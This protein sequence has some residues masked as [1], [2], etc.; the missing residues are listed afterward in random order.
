[1][2]PSP[3]GP[4]SGSLPPDYSILAV[5]G[6][7]ERRVTGLGGVFFRSKNPKRLANWYRQHLGLDVT[8]EGGQTFWPFQWKQRRGAKR[9]GVTIWAPFPARSRYFGS[10]RQPIMMNYI[11]EDLDRVLRALRSERVEIIGGVEKSEY[12]RF[13]WI[14]D[15]EGHRVELWEPSQSK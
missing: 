4:G 9:N 15:G 7:M 1:M 10:Q 6:G 12:G 13:A 8:T 2:S 11:V 14:R 3:A 5:S